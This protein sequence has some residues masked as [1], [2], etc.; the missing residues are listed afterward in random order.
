MKKEHSVDIQIRFNDIDMMGH[1]YNAKYQDFFDLARLKYFEEV[2]GDLITWSHKGL[3]IA[4]VNVDYMEPTFLK[5][6]INVVT[7]VSRLGDKSIEMSQE[8]YKKG[9]ENPVAVCRSVM[10][11]FNMH[12][13]FSM[14]IPDE[15]R[16]RFIDAEPELNVNQPVGQN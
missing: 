3:V 7:C 2:L 13:R 4:S 8:I 16:R 6:K 11:Y 10:V 12:E 1:V 14:S 5:D 15:W 9:Y